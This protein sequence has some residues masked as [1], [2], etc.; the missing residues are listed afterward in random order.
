[1]NALLLC[2][3]G[4]KEFSSFELKDKQTVQYRGNFGTVLTSSVAKALVQALLSDP[5]ATDAHI[6][7]QIKDY[8][9]HDPLNGPASFA[10]DINLAGDD[11]LLCFFMNMAT[12]KW[13]QLGSGWKSSLSAVCTSAGAPLWLNLLCCTQLDGA[14]LAQA[15]VDA[16]LAVK[17]WATVFAGK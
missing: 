10:P 15:G 13:I 12:R 2:H 16:K 4:L 5:L 1:M 14:T 17:D 7:A 11:K 6:A 9:P 8:Q 3:G